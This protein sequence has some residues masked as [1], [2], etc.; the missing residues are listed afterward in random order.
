MKNNTTPWSYRAGASI[1]HRLPAGL[2][3]AFLLLLS[4]A[5]FFPGTERHIFVILSIVATILIILSFMA[6]IKPWRLLRG[7]GPLLVL[8]ISVFLVQG[9]ELSPF[10]FK[11]DG[12]REAVIFCI[13]IGTAFAA[14]SLLF[15]ITTTGEIRKSISRAEAAVHLEKLKIG[16]SIALMLGFLKKFF[17]IWEDINLAWKSR[18]GRKNLRQFKIL[19]P[20]VIE[21]MM[22]K[23]IETASAMESRGL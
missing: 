17:E 18:G 6:G 22:V 15:A 12:L 3:L 9:I 14:G 20:L 4:L 23:A 8:I 10:G 13:R 21:K 1:L 7:S 19:V 5:V 2:K 16:I 11:A